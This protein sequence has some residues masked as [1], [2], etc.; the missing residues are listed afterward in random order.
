MNKIKQGDWGYFTGKAFSAYTLRHKVRLWIG[1]QGNLSEDYYFFSL[2]KWMPTFVNRI[3]NK[4]VNKI[5]AK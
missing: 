5:P 4:I 1:I 3:L 2:P